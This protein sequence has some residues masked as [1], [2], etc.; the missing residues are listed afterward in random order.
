MYYLFKNDMVD[1]LYKFQYLDVTMYE[2]KRKR[3]TEVVRCVEKYLNWINVGFFFIWNLYNIIF[4]EISMII[5][6]KMK[7]I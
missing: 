7:K 6:C 3:S 1:V 5:C 4:E 2:E